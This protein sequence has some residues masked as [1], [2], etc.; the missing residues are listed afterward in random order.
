MIDTPSRW[1]A[2]PKVHTQPTLANARYSAGFDTPANVSW[3]Q[4]TW[5]MN[6]IINLI[7]MKY[8]NIAELRINKSM[9]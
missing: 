6:I 8:R 7:E 9:A 2:P 5:L 3:A 4:I 1:R